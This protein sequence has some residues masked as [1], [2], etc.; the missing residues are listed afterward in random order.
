VATSL[1]NLA[2]MLKATGR[3][4]EADRLLK[5]AAAIRSGKSE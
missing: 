3:H 4:A 1:D 2:G 5:R